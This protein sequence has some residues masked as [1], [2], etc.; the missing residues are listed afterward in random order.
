[1]HAPD[2]HT[3]LHVRR[4]FAASRERVF[5]AWT[6]PRELERWF[7]PLGSKVRVTHLDLRVAGAYRFELQYPE[8][9]VT[10]IEGNYVEIARPERLAFTWSFDGTG[11]AQTLV[12]V[13]FVEEGGATEVRLTHERLADEAMVQ[14]H[15][16][17][18]ESCLDMLAQVLE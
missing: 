1:M 4:R 6:E 5:Q 17:G 14:A 3:S 12:T 7:R 18:W 11:G 10:Y 2:A 15:R 16:A 13:E 8:G 9:G